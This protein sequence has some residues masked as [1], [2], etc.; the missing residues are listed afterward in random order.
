MPH[1]DGYGG[2]AAQAWVR[3]VLSTYGDTC[4][5]CHHRGADSGDHLQPRA[6]R[7]DLMYVVSN[8][9]P[10]HHKACPTC[11]V[12]CNIRRKAKPLSA[13]PIRDSLAFFD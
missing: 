1:G 2:R 11:G 3:L 5:L 7:P 8:G 13:A 12:R 10:V 6:D 4:H 9:R